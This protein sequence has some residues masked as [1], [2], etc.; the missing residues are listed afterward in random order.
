[1]GFLKILLWVIANAPTLLSLVK[2]I[3]DLI[4]NLPKEQQGQA[5]LD[6]MKAIKDKELDGFADSLKKHC[7]GVAC[8]ADLV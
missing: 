3:I 7:T 1:M 4:K 6:L 5:K 8:P 2:Q